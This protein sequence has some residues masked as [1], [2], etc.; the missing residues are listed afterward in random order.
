LN[1]KERK[2]SSF[3]L[4]FAPEKIGEFFQR[5]NSFAMI[6]KPKFK[7]RTSS[8]ISGG[9]SVSLRFAFVGR[10]FPTGGWEKYGHDF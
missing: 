2:S 9:L 7:E 5:K 3:L 6:R 10:R 4:G 8:W 1:E